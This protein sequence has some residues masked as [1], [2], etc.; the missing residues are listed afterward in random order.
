[1]SNVKCQIATSR[2]IFL[3][4]NFHSTV[5]FVYISICLSVCAKLLSECGKISSHLFKIY[6]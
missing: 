5:L 4:Q 3:L 2:V 1:M 6:I